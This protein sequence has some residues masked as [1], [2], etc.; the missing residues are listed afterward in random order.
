[1]V[2]HM[3][4]RLPF[5]SE[6]HTEVNAEGVRNGQSDTYELLYA[7]SAKLDLGGK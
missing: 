2:F 7:N 3:Y 1:M 5:S 6:L 4:S